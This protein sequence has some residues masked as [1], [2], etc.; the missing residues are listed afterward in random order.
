MTR[1][2]IIE[3]RAKID[4]WLNAELRD[5]AARAEAERRKAEMNDFIYSLEDL[6]K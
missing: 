3:L 1:A 6:P 5:A 2:Q 4:M